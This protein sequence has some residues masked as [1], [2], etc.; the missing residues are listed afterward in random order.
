MGALP[1]SRIAPR[2]RRARRTHYKLEAVKLVRC[3]TCDAYH[4]PH[5]VC[6]A[7]GSFRGVQVIEEPTEE[8]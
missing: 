1:K 4:R 2:R 3:T 7:C 8:A 5:H 6:H